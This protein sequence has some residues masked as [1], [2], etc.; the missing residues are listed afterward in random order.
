MQLATNSPCGRGAVIGLQRRHGQQFADQAQIAVQQQR[1][2]KQ[3]EIFPA[4]LRVA[5][6]F[7]SRPRHKVGVA[8][9]GNFAGFAGREPL[10][11]AARFLSMMNWLAAEMFRVGPFSVMRKIRL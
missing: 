4:A 2:V 11:I 3:Q 1:A 10:A 6:E 5:G 8:A 7:Q 9:D